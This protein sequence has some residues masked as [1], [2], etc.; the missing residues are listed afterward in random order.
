MRVT[1]AYHEWSNL[2]QTRFAADEFGFARLRKPT[3]IAKG[4][5]VGPL[6]GIPLAIV[7]FTKGVY[8]DVGRK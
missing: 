2:P 6:H 5:V 3:A 8:Q 1:E 4:N 7:Y